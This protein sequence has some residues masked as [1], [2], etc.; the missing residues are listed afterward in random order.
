MPPRSARVFN[1]GCFGNVGVSR[2]RIE[3]PEV[4]RAIG[5]PPRSARVLNLGFTGNVGVPRDRIEIPEVVRA[6]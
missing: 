2:D 5:V 1:V 6:K 4:V 3:I